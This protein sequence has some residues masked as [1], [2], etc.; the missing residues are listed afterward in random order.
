MNNALLL[1]AEDQK[2]FEPLYSSLIAQHY[3]VSLCLESTTEVRK[4]LLE[5]HFTLVIFTMQ[6]LQQQHINLMQIIQQYAPK[7]VVLF[8]DRCSEDWIVK[9]VNAGA[10]SIVVNDLNVQRLN[11][12]FEIAIARFRRCMDLRE[13][14]STTKQ[15]LVE[16]R[17]IERAKGILMDKNKI[18]ENEA[19]HLLRKIAMDNNSRIADIAKSILMTSKW[20]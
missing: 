4:Q 18:S 19:Y 11:S 7:P 13:E 12:I 3:A 2:R 9:A 1:I 8:A 10:N 16:R 6:H 17:D 15:K 14:I 20:L 5:T